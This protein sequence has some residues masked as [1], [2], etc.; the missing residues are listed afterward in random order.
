M[1]FRYYVAKNGFRYISELQQK[2]AGVEKHRGGHRGHSNL[3]LTEN[4]RFW[5]FVSNLIL[6][7]NFLQIARTVKKRLISPMTT[8]T[9]R[10]L[11]TPNLG[12]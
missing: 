5:V 7:A 2:A 6:G 1:L 10:K 11:K 3:S 8:A 4:G 12:W 9:L